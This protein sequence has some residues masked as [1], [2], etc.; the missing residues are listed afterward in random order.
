MLRVS[1]AGLTVFL[2]VSP[3]VAETLRPDLY[4]GAPRGILDV[5]LTFSGTGQWN[6]PNGVEYTKLVASRTANMQL[7]MVLADEGRGALVAIQG[8]DMNNLELPAARADLQVALAACGN[9]KLCLFREA[10][11]YAAA[12]EADADGTDFAELPEDRFYNWVS[13]RSQPCV[14]GSLSVQDTGSGVYIPVPDPAVSFTYDRNGEQNLHAAA[15]YMLERICDARLTYDTEE[16]Y[17]SLRLPAYD[18]RVP[19]VL[20]GGVDYTGE[21]T[22]P[23]LEGGPEHFF[24]LDNLV[25]WRGGSASGQFTIDDVGDAS[26]GPYLQVPL[27]VNVA[28]TFT[29]NDY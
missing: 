16:G 18:L 28:W 5:Q 22:L 4:P 17:V 19:T 24:S 25:N 20:S 7:A 23:L 14:Y 21:A 29:P 10:M 11:E 27:S 9:E 15:D 3:S 8:H 1:I 2:I 6:S 26:V 13:D 12:E